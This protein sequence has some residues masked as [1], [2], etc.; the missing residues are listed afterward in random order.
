MELDNDEVLATNKY[1]EKE[2]DKI[3]SSNLTDEQKQNKLDLI[4]SMEFH[5]LGEPLNTG[6]CK[7]NYIQDEP[8]HYIC[9]HCGLGFLIK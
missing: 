8:K 2:I 9:S 7:H 5:K 6:R 4:E 3:N 1:K